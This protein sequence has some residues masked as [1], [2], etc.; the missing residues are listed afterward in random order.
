MKELFLSPISLAIVFAILVVVSLIFI[1]LTAKS[2]YTKPLEKPLVFLFLIGIFPIPFLP[3]SLTAPDR[4]SVDNLS[5]T[6]F[7]TTSIIYAVVLFLLKRISFPDL[8]KGLLLVFKDP[9]LLML[10]TMTVASMLWSQT[11]F[12]T[13]CSSVGMVGLTVL[14]AQTAKKYSWAELEQLLRWV[15]TVIGLLS[16]PIALFLP[17]LRLYGDAWGGFVSNSKLLGSLMALNVILWLVRLVYEPK[18]KI[19]AAGMIGLSIVINIF[20]LAKSSLITLAVLLY[21]FFSLRLLQFYKFRQSIIVF[22]FLIVMSILLALAVSAGIELIFQALGKDPTLTGRTVFWEQLIDTIARSPLGYGYNGFWQ[23]WRGIENPAVF[24]G[25]GLEGDYRPPHAH[26]GFLDVGLQLGF[27]G[28]L[29]FLLSFAK[30]L[31][32]A[33]WRTQFHRGSEAVFPLI[34]LVFLIMSNTSESQNMGLI[35][36]NYSWFLYALMAIKMNLKIHQKDDK[37]NRAEMSLLTYSE[38]R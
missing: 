6:G 20:T 4:L 26:N 37:F 27:I 9:L 38:Q 29:I 1:K 18:G 30:T 33:I 32:A 14:A 16:V 22:I 23:P 12:L 25:A 35:G 34:I 8:P 21:L 3:F 10:P 19:L 7:I 17:S 5:P 11:P 31:I 13:L 28:L 2:Q 36:P 15:L 24:I